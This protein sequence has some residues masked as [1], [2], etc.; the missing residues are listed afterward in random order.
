MG[1]KCIKCTGN[2]EEEMTKIAMSSSALIVGFA[3]FIK[4]IYAP[5][6]YKLKK[7]YSVVQLRRAIYKRQMKVKILL[8]FV[9]VGSRL[10]GT[11]R[12]KIPSMAKNFFTGVQVLEFFDVFR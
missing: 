4:F 5:T 11:F 8:A 6:M 12:I 9:Q 3:L 10:Q 1:A 7:R 2:F